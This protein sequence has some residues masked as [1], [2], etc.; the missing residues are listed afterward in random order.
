LLGTLLI[1]AGPFILLEFL[2]QNALPAMLSIGQMS[3]FLTLLRENLSLAYVAI[4]ARL[5]F[6]FY[7]PLLL[8]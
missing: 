4:R 2:I 7:S 3:A 5:L 1:L 6:H 8:S